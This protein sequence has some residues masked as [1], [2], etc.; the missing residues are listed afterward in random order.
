MQTL[1]VATTGREGVWAKCWIIEKMWKSCGEKN[2]HA[3]QWHPRPQAHKQ[4]IPASWPGLQAAAA[5]DSCAP[6]WLQQLTYCLW[7]PG[8][9]SL[10]DCCAVLAAGLE[11]GHWVTVAQGESAV[12]LRTV[13]HGLKVAHRQSVHQKADSEYRGFIHSSFSAWTNCPMG[14]NCNY[15]RNAPKLTFSFFHPPLIWNLLGINLL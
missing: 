12:L 2:I 10:R 7:I 13:T 5:N 9:Q 4:V 3:T 1:N 8:R 15:W 14:K 6:C 11:Q